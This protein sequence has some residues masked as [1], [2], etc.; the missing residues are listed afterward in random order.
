MTF[1]NCTRTDVG[2]DRGAF[3]V[4]VKPDGVTTLRF[5]PWPSAPRRVDT[6][7]PCCTGRTLRLPIKETM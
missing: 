3:V 7:C 6:A 5:V 1:Q 2:I 4:P